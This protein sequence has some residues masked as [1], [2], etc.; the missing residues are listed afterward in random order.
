MENIS[1]LVIQKEVESKFKYDH[2]IFVLL[3]FFMGQ[4]DLTFGLYPFSLI[5]WSLFIGSNIYLFLF[6]SLSTVSGLVFAGGLYNLTYC[7]GIAGLLLYKIY[8]KKFESKEWLAAF[9]ICLSYL[10]TSFTVNFFNNVLLYRYLLKAGES[11]LIFMLILIVRNGS[12]EFS[13]IKKSLSKLEKLTVLI[14]SIGVLLGLNAI[15]YYGV[16]INIIVLLIIIGSTYAAGTNL[17]LFLAAIYG[18]VFVSSGVIPMVAMTKYIIFALVCALFTHKKK[19]WMCLGFLLGFMLYS[20]FSPSM[21]DI[22][23]TL[24]ET[25]FVLLIFILM[26]PF[27]WDYLFKRFA[28]TSKIVKDAEINKRYEHSFKKQLRELSAVFSELSSTFQEVLPAEEK[29]KNNRIEDFIF[30]FKNKNCKKC[31]DKRK[32]WYNNKQKTYDVIENMLV[33][34]RKKGKIDSQIC[35]QYLSEICKYSED[36]VTGVQSSFELF[37][38]NNF[39]RNRLIEKQKTVSDQLAGIGNIVEDF[40][41]NTGLDFNYEVSVDKIKTKLTKNNINVCTINING[42]KG[43]HRVDI[44]MEIEPCRGNEPCSSKILNILNSE[45]DYNF[46]LLTNKC[47]NILKER[48]CF[49]HYGPTGLYKI[50]LAVSQRAITEDTS[51]DTMRHKKLDNGQ[52]LVILSDGM[53]VGKR[54]ARESKAAVNLFENIIRSG[55]N[56]DLAIKTINSALFLRNQEERFTTMDIA[57]FDTFSAEL[58]MEKIGAMSTYIKRGWEVISLN[59]YSLPVGILEKIETCSCSKQLEE[60]DIVFMLSD[61]LLDAIS[62]VDDREEWFKQLL[63]KISFTDPRDYTKYIEEV[64][65]KKGKINDDLSIVVFKVRKRKI[66]SGRKEIGGLI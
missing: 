25:G 66:F 14:I 48:P 41:H 47:G 58:K 62:G 20:G 26:P 30:L 29:E 10:F 34:A 12:K 24:I 23:V 64:I 18:L 7:A 40:A 49:L 19:I 45:F 16:I 61:G 4:A 63:R 36:I 28:V 50:D 21:Y 53:G 3:A 42:K 1:S 27:I 8:S 46:R 52:D 51:G 56:K 17:G 65:S 15:P 37:Q 2:L 35:K 44:K 39:W 54:A 9:F 33:A 55:F 59:S 11:I 5:Y 57:F 43:S 22:K 31:T 38:V 6:V 32:C 13:L 60:D